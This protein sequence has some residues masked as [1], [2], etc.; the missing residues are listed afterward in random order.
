M[1]C[2]VS[3]LLSFHC[4]KKVAKK[5]LGKTML[6]RSLKYCRNS[7]QRITSPQAG[8]FA[9]IPDNISFTPAFAPPFCRANA[10]ILLLKKAEDNGKNCNVDS[11]MTR[12]LRICVKNQRNLSAL[13]LGSNPLSE[14]RKVFYS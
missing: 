6:Q 2:N 9:R 1:N 12:I 7:K 11:L 14:Q 4:Q 8:C 5:K 3:I 13:G 10:L